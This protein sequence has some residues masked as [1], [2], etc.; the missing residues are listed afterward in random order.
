MKKKTIYLTWFFTERDG[1]FFFLKRNF[2]NVGNSKNL[3]VSGGM[4]LTG[5]TGPRDVKTARIVTKLTLQ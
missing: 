5:Y 4:K 2:E 1:I 3:L